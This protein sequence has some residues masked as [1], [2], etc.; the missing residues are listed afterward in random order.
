MKLSLIEA[1]GWYGMVAVVLAYALVSFAVLQASDLAYQLLNI[2][3]SIGLA[4]V[5]FK[6][7]AYQP[8]VLNIVWTAI[9]LAAVARIFVR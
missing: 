8:G 9:A 5:S 4:V 7:K 2:T 3:G 6:K 1:V